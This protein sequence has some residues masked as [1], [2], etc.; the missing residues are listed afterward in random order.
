MIH[1]QSEPRAPATG[2]PFVASCL[3]GF[4]PSARNP[5][6]PL[7]ALIRAGSASARAPAPLRLEALFGLARRGRHAIHGL[8]SLI[9]VLYSSPRVERS[10][11]AFYEWEEGIGQ[12]CP[13]WSNP[14]TASFR[15][16]EAREKNTLVSKRTDLKAKSNLRSTQRHRLGKVVS[17]ETCFTHPCFTGC[18]PRQ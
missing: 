14:R 5:A 1:R 15:R 7:G 11:C 16:E 3:L 12:S 10:P 17:R 8:R 6:L 18:P 4:V 13:A 2:S 9:G